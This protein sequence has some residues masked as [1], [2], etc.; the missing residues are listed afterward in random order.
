MFLD[1]ILRYE[2][3]DFRRIVGAFFNASSFRTREYEGSRTCFDGA[4]NERVTLSDFF[5]AGDL[6]G[7][8]ACWGRR[9]GGKDSGDIVEVAGNE[10]D[11][12]RFGG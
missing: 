2:M 8:D 5:L 4:V 11:G 12:G 10:R 6:N 3:L 7:E 9:K 1:L